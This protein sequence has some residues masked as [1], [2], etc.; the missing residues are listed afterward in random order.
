MNNEQQDAFEML[1]QALVSYPILNQPNMSKPFI[2]FTDAS[3]YCMGAV[4]SQKDDEGR[5][6]PIAYISKKF[7]DAEIYWTVSEKECFACVWAIKK[8]RIYLLGQKFTIVTDHSALSWLMNLKDPNGRLARWSIYL[9]AYEFEIIHRK[10]LI[11]ANADT[12]SRPVLVIARA[13]SRA[14]QKIDTQPN[15]QAI[16]INDENEMEV[17]PN[18]IEDLSSKIQDVYDDAGLLYFLEKGKTVL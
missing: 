8:F 13:Q 11:H 1:K 4:L 3:G 10:G 18:E 2:L 5:E 17:D 15:D 14:N 12:L 7:K 16:V 6:H 9:Q